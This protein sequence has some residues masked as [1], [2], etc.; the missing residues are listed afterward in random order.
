M[1]NTDMYVRYVPIKDGWT[2]EINCNGTTIKSPDSFYTKEMA[3]RD[4]DLVMTSVKRKAYQA[5]KGY[6][7]DSHVQNF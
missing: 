2:W 4:A 7:M 1:L 5:K 3:R 6:I